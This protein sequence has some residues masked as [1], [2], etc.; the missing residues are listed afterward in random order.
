DGHVTGRRTRDVSRSSRQRLPSGRALA[1]GV[2]PG[3]GLRSSPSGHD[4]LDTDNTLSARRPEPNQNAHAA[5]SRNSADSAAASG[6]P[7]TNA[8]GDADPMVPAPPPPVSPVPLPPSDGVGVE[9]PVGLL[10][11][12][13]VPVPRI[14]DVDG[15]ANG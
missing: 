6:S 4:E 3:D 7:P 12:P 5:P 13:I 2:P 8:R 15:S 1:H 10:D 9:K 11:E 14:D